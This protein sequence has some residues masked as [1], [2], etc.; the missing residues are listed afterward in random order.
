MAPIDIL[1]DDERYTEAQPVSGRP[2]NGLNKMMII[3]G[4]VSDGLS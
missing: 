4:N 3:E 1:Q 2:A